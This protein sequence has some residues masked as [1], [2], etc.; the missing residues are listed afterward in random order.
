MINLTSHGHYTIPTSTT[1][2]LKLPGAFGLSTTATH[3]LKL[4]LT[5]SGKMNRSALVTRFRVWSPQ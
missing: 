3:S 2:H 4:E 5:S 1:T